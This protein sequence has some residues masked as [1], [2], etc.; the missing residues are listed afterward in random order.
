MQ[1]TAYSAFRL[2]YCKHPVIAPVAQWIEHRI[3]NPGAARP[4]RAGGTSKTKGF[5]VKSEALF[6]LQ[7]FR[8]SPQNEKG[9]GGGFD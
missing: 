7:S 6:L 5:R 2:R 1:K 9:R 4:I 3:P 8:M